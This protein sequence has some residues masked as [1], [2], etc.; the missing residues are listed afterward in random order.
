MNSAC[1]Y[2]QFPVSDNFYFCPN[3]GKKLIEPPL[4]TTPIKQLKLYLISFFLPPFGILPS[5]KYIMEK[6]EKA[7]IIGVISLVLSIVSIIL[8]INLAIN[9]FSNPLGS[10]TKQLQELRNLGY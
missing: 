5:I 1:K 9:L 6:N 2:C 3:C 10:D 7:K 8:T 4:P